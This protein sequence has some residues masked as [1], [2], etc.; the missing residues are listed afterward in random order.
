MAFILQLAIL[1]VSVFVFGA[2]Y[3]YNSDSS[4]QH[5][6]KN[7][8]INIITEMDLIKLKGNSH[9]KEIHHELVTFDKQKLKKKSFKVNIVKLTKEQEML[10]NLRQKILSRRNMLDVEHTD[11]QLMS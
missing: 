5:T 4:A 9:H 7:L 1:G 3:L 10:E 11:I 2:G 6:T 8:D